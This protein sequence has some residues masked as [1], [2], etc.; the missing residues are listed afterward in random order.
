MYCMRA[1]GRIEEHPRHGDST[2][3]RQNTAWVD[4]EHVD[5]IGRRG[6]AGRI[7]VNPEVL[8]H[9]VREQS[10]TRRRR[11]DC[12]VVWDVVMYLDDRFGTRA[13]DCQVTPKLQG[14]HSR[15][16]NT[17][18][19]RND[20]FTATR[21]THRSERQVNGAGVVCRLG[22]GGWVWHFIVRITIAYG[23]TVCDDVERTPDT[24]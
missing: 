15:R 8:N 21:R 9:H 19:G 12:I 1:D 10:D 4:R 16:H 11:K 7:L 18:T 20:D 24:G 13:A 5:S 3:T 22:A 23:A 6:V 2:G 17:H 14:R